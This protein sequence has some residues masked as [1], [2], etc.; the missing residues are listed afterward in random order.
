MDEIQIEPYAQGLRG[1]VLDLSLR[2]WEPVFAEMERAVPAFVY[3]A[4]YPD[5]WRARQ[6]ADIGAFL[7]RS[8][9][10]VYVAT[11]AREVLGWMGLRFHPEDRM[12]E[13]YIIAV[14]PRHQRQGV[15]HALMQHGYEQMQEQGLE[16]VMV[17]TGGDPGHAASRATYESAGFERWPVARYFRRL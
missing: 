8:P 11:R 2:A 14:D 17:E 13:I 7:D 1:V 4:F 3:Q 5:G 6:L 16:M 15:A 10:Q 12:G 9:D